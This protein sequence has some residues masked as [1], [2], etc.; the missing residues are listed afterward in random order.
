MS[1]FYLYGNSI[2]YKL[3]DSD[4][5]IS[6]NLGMKMGRE[7]TKRGII[8]VQGKL[9]EVM[10]IFTILF[11]VILYLYTYVKTLLIY[12]LNTFSILCQLHDK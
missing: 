12:S 5:K 9:W 10:D 3:I 4:R 6:N 7:E 1:W 8:Y 11:V 2:K